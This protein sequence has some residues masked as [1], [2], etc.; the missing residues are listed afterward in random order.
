MKKIIFLQIFAVL[1]SL[2]GQAQVNQKTSTN[3]SITDPAGDPVV[4]LDQ[5][6]DGV[7]CNTI[8]DFFY[9]DGYCYS[10]TRSDCD[11][12]DPSITAGIWFLDYDQDGYGNPLVP[13]CV[14]KVGYVNNNLD[15]FDS[16]ATIFPKTWYA[17]ADGD[18]F[19]NSAV[20]II[21][22]IKPVGYVSNNTD[23]DDANANINPNTKWYYDPTGGAVF[24]DME[25]TDPMPIIQCN[26][27]GPNYTTA[28]S[29]QANNF[30]FTH[31]ISYDIKG[32]ITS[33]SRTYFDELGKSNI[34]LS[35]D[36]VSNKV[37]G[38]ETTYDDQGRPDKTSFAAPS[39]LTNLK[40]IGFLSTSTAYPST[41]NLTTYYSN[42]NTDEP[43]Q[44]TA[45]QPYSQSNYDKL[46]PG[47]VVNVIGGNQIE[48][49]PGVFEWKTGRAYTVT[50]AQELYYVYGYNYYDGTLALGKEEVITKFYKSVSVD[51]NGNENVSFS[52][53]EGKV[54]ASARSGGTTS[55]PIVSTIGTQG[56]VDVHIPTGS[57][58]PITLLGGASLYDVYDL[59]ANTG[60]ITTA[61]LQAGRAYRIVAKT[62]PTVEPL[63][64]VANAAGGAITTSPNAM[65]VSYGVNYYD[66]A[67]NIYNKTG[68]LIK[69]V[70]PNGFT[71][72][73]PSNITMSAAPA[74][75]PSTLTNFSSIYAYD[76]LGQVI[77]ATSSD[78]GTSRFAYRQ[79]GQIRYSQSALQL[80]ANKV[81]YTNYDSYARPIESGVITGSTGIWAAAQGLVDLS[82]MVAGVATEQTVTIYDDATNN[83]S[84]ITMPANQSLASV[85][86]TAGLTSAQIA[87][88]T[89]KNL[90]GN[91]AMTFTKPG[92]SITA[93]TWYSYD[94]YGRAEWV[95]QFND[96]IGA[97]TIDYEYDYQGNV[98]KVI[99]QKYRSGELFAHEYTYD[100]NSVLTDVKTS[101]TNI[102]GSFI[103][104]AQY[105]YYKTG[106]LKRTY[107]QQAQQGLDYVYT[108]GGALKSINHP[109]LTP[110]NDPGQDSN[111]LFGMTLDYYKD[112]YI[113][114]G[115][116]IVSS[117]NIT[118]SNQDFNGN[119]KASRWANK[120]SLMDWANGTTS[121]KGY[122]YN[123]DR[124]NWLTGATFGNTASTPTATITPLT[125]YK[126][127]NLTYDPNGNIKKLQRTNDAGTIVD[128]LSYEYPVGNGNKLDRVAEAAPITTDPTDI[129]N[130]LPN[131]YS[132]DA[133]GQMTK[134]I[135]ENIS[136]EYN[137][138]GLVLEVRNLTSG[139]PLVK[140]FYN[141]RGQR[142]KKESYD[143]PAGGTL[144][145][146]TYYI[147]DLAGNAMANYQQAA[148]SVIKQ[149]ELPIYGA[150][151]LGVYYRATGAMSYQLTDHLGNV[152]AVVT[153]QGVNPP[154]MTSYADYYPFG[155]QLPR[156][157]SMSGYR[158]AFQGQE[159]DSETN[160]EAFQ[161][162]LWD[163]RI[164]RWLSPDPY[165][166][167]ASPY[168]GMGNNPISLID[169]DGGSTIDPAMFSNLRNDIGAYFSGLNA[170]KLQEIVIMMPKKS[171]GEISIKIDWFSQYLAPTSDPGIF[172]C[173]R[174]CYLMAENSGYSPI[175]GNANGIFI[176]KEYNGKDIV[177]LPKLSQGIK[178]LN[179]QLKLGNPV[180][181]GV[182]RDLDPY[183]KKN[184]NNDTTT[185]HF[186]VIYGV[187]KGSYKFFDPGT[188]QKSFG[189]SRNNLLNLQST[190][191]YAGNRSGQKYNLTLSWIGRNN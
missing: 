93:I 157:N 133:I 129:E 114:A 118:G 17:D 53:G 86:P 168:L 121:Q 30:N 176:G 112:D 191:L 56:F 33:I 3:I 28:L 105:S 146:T 23:C 110:L 137:T 138:Q 141:E 102:P 24:S 170:I 22:C 39:P 73:F 154:T 14:S 128:D 19:G 149:S 99:F 63:T 64:Y 84:S 108:L 79:D 72:A 15:C 4:Y 155:E 31:G 126:E 166:Q 125:K 67:V 59:T 107:L 130:Q 61:P 181:V 175:H 25:M 159:L 38:T 131:N 180:I 97:K 177:P 136:Y 165:G 147:V 66:F 55:Y 94:I 34:S 68:Q 44:A 167:Y 1:A 143:I 18:S 187:H 27:P 162:R 60:L 103:A 10:T 12:N 13:S 26:Q 189:T 109:S 171:I 116:N 119:I 88:Y 152:R 85:L 42:N 77:V 87:L 8:Y 52:D 158:Y 185:D 80:P 54:L 71:Q 83:A 178:Y 150:S 78:E 32:N 117:S 29:S 92:A 182:A 120:N 2:L 41:N 172:A 43:Y 100:A 89:Q 57:T 139:K 58:T 6:C 65:G 11:D 156:R 70:Q 49:S 144:Q 62:Y 113:R 151:R 179:N 69:T 115:T 96:G 148:N 95:V 51:A 173:K 169:P 101:T 123:Y 46:N 40:K 127:G 160:M 106:E 163:G 104:Q 5:D 190:G 161:L 36:L 90:S 183:R 111:D 135:S 50:A 82:T 81:S 37:W 75:M 145:S 184:L 142:I 140:F 20:T 16:N 124:N 153:K 132:Y 45:T 48:T 9:H 174:A 35:K 134:N 186:I 98:K 7:G 91:V 21:N 122:L 164:G 47:G 188:R 76:N 74:Y